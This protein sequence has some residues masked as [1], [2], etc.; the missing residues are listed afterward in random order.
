MKHMNSR[1]SKLASVLALALASFASCAQDGFSGFLEDLR[2]EA[3]VSGISDET[4][5][6]AVS[7]IEFLPDV[8]ALDRSQPEFI[9]PFL[10]YYQKRVNAAKVQRGR[11]LLLEHEAMF[12]RIEA[13]YGVSKYT[14]AAFWG[15]ETQ[16]GR[17]QGKLDI[18]SSLATLAYDGRRTEFFRGQLL[19]AMR[20]I[21]IGHVAPGALTGSWAGAFG[22]MQF[23]PTTFMMYA[24]DGDSDN[25][26]DVVDSLPDAIASAANYLSQVGWHS[27]EPAM[28]EVQL[29][30]GFD[31]GSAQLSVRKPVAEWSR[32][33]VRALHVDAGAP[34]FGSGAAVGQ[35][36]S[37]KKTRLNPENIKK[38]ATHKTDKSKT[39]RPAQPE[40]QNVSVGTV[41]L[42]VLGLQVKGPAA[43]L[44][45]QGYRGPAFMVFDNFDVI[46]DWNRSVNYAL[47]V[48]Q[49][50]EQLRHESRIVGGKFAEE[51][52]LSFQEML[53]LQ[54]MLN[55]RGFDAGEPDGLPGLM[56]QEAI[57]KYQ[58]ANQLPAD[59]YASRSLY[60]RLYAEQQ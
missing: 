35:E 51:G 44:L 55:T 9:S 46:M 33:G 38:P 21:D 32:L 36:V 41:S 3:M 15:M 58:V 40:Q 47:S 50:A 12:N 53:D 57:R 59:G 56:T 49:L 5:N 42:D 4:A 17:N 34:G 54:T 24:V 27:D 39:Q 26:I 20:M 37:N 6:N 7:H 31:W 30:T 28:L 19:D 1:L 23:M 11:Q 14:L 10:D 13:Q 43:I 25:L 48:A 52:A 18:L 29:P 45:P 16:Y 8:I 2:I 60:Q 22:N